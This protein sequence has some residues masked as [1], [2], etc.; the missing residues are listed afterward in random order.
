MHASEWW[1]YK[2]D[3]LFVDS[4]VKLNTMFEM[5]RRDTT[6][7]DEQVYLDALLLREGTAIVHTITGLKNSLLSLNQLIKKGHVPL[8]TEDKMSICDLRNTTITV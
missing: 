8:F 1:R 2:S 5:A 4:G 6:V 7:A 3:P